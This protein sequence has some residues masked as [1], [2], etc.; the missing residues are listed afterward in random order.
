MATFRGHVGHDTGDS[1]IVGWVMWLIF[2]EENIL[3]LSFVV[4]QIIQYNNIVIRN[5]NKL[6]NIYIT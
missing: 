3:R 1:G 4:I 2:G 6:S 5:I